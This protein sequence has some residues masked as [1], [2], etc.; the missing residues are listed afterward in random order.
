[1]AMST[2]KIPSPGRTCLNVERA[3]CGLLELVGQLATKLETSLKIED[4]SVQT[5]LWPEHVITKTEF[6]MGSG[7]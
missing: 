3:D 7:T 2:E 6:G 1:M 4:G 5:G